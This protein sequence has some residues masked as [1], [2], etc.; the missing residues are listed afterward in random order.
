MEIWCEPWS[1]VHTFSSFDF[2][3]QHT[4]CS[5]KIE[6]GDTGQQ[7]RASDTV[8]FRGL[9][10]RLMRLSPPHRD[11]D[12]P[13]QLSGPR[14]A[15][16]PHRTMEGELRCTQKPTQRIRK[17]VRLRTTGFITGAVERIDHVKTPEL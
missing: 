12:P 16:N 1:I 17:E 13:P 4:L 10:A 7:S 9:R 14:S 6:S 8:P 2:V 5:K 15:L 11:T 3:V